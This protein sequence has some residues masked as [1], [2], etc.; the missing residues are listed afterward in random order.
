M[1]QPSEF[2]VFNT[3]RPVFADIRV[4]QALTLLFDFEW[5]NR[6]YFFG[7]Y[8]RSA[9][10]FAGSELS[11][12][13]RPADDR[14]R[15]LLKPFASRMPPDILDGSYRLPAS[16]GSGRDRAT[17]RAA[18]KLLSEAGY[19]LDG[20]VLRQRSSKTPLSFEILVTTRDQERIALAYVR[21]LK[22]AGIEVSV[23]SVDAV[24]FEQRRLGF[25]FD[26]IQNRWDQSLSPGQRAILLLGQRGRRHPGHAELHGRP[27][28]R[29]RRHDRGRSGGARAARFR[30]RGAG[31]GP[32]PDVRVLRYSG[33]EPSR[34]MDR[35]LE[36]DRTAG[37]HR[38]DRVP[39][40]DLVAEAG[41]ATEVTP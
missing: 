18:L 23:R 41:P 6:N 16:D 15:E 22:R 37:S 10:F 13:G 39:P 21:D 38:V 27:G 4:R 29:H 35:A 20:T 17:L 2:L 32:H 28:S 31:A 26:M 11:A 24:Q 34:A 9:G 25:D 14:E 30:L 19:D 3:R 1:P 7:L 36:S 5:I 40:G 8:A 33:I 12:Y